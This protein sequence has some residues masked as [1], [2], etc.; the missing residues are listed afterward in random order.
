M[1]FPMIWSARGS[2][3]FS[4]MPMSILRQMRRFAPLTARQPKQS[5][6]ERGIV[7]VPFLFGFGL[8]TC[9]ADE[10]IQWPLTAMASDGHVKPSLTATKGAEVWY[11]PLQTDNLK[12]DLHELRRLVQRHAEEYLHRQTYLDRHIAEARL[13]ATLTRRRW[14][15]SHIWIRQDRKR[16]APLQRFI[17]SQPVRGLVL[18]SGPTAHDLQLS[19]LLHAVNSSVSL[20]NKA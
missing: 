5:T 7:G 2:S 12:Q 19:R 15:P 18:R 16:S 20:C 3:V 1:L 17:T 8:D 14:L 4:S 13:S 11:H 6:C 10:K 9:T